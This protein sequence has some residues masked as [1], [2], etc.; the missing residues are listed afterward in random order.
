MKGKRAAPRARADHA[1]QV[2]AT[3]AEGIAAGLTP[4]RGLTTA[5]VAQ[6]YRVSEDKV[7]AWIKSGKLKAIDTSD[8]RCGKPR[9]VVLP[10]QL[11]EFERSR[12]TAPTPKPKPR[13]RA[14]GTKDYF[15]GL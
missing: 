8:V 2:A 9:F 14:D 7:R 10:E 15:P 6:R 13:R 11:A 12:S 4:G 5:E 1:R 3:E